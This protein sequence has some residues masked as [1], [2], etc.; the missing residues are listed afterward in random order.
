MRDHQA[1]AANELGGRAATV[2]ARGRLSRAVSYSPARVG[3]L[4]GKYEVAGRLGGGGMAEVFVASVT[5]AE[6]FARRVAVKRV[7][8][9]FSTNP[10]FAKM[11]VAEAKISSRLQ[12]PNIV[13]VLD[14]DRDEEERLFLVMELIEGKD[15]DALAA[16]GPL[17]ISVIIFVITEALRGLGYAHDLP[18]VDDVAMRGSVTIRA[19]RGVVHRDVSPH[20]VLLS[21]EGVVKVSDFGIAKARN[22]T[23]ATA[24]DVIKGKPAYMSPEQ[25]NGEDL[26]GR[27]DLF[28]IGVMLW[29]LLCG[30]RLF[31]GDDTRSMLAAVLFRAIPRP[32][33]VRAA[34]PKDLERVVMKLLERD[35]GARYE[36]AEAVIVDLVACVAAPKDGRAEL[37]RVMAERF[38]AE[39]PVRHSVLRVRQRDGSDAVPQHIPSHD[40]PTIAMT[41][42]PDPQDRGLP[43]A[44]GLPVVSPIRSRRG[45]WVVGSVALTAIT[46]IIT[47]AVAA[48]ARKSEGPPPPV[49]AAPIAAVDAQTT[50]FVPPTQ[51]ADLR[52]VSSDARVTD[53]GSANAASDANDANDAAAPP[54][55]DPKPDAKASTQLARP[56]TEKRGRLQVRAF[57]S[58]TVYIDRRKLHDT[59]LD[60]QLAVGNHSVRLVNYDIGH[61]ETVNVIIRENQTTIIER[62]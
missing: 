54:V 53:A 59:P 29:E 10:A 2:P 51:D 18:V 15:L 62:D 44:H 16:S 46:A 4:S 21:W 25:A 56:S 12:H 33:T 27:S 20:N 42:E 5:G 9:G 38:S 43:G 45:R 7:L 11:F 8:P 6:G 49:G 14:F 22:T 26:D 58:L 57:P 23:S 36:T 37:K 3:V 1:H 24:S 50:A 31:T 35:L 61:D 40:R 17:P 28:A 47:L 34:I 39:A 32:R 13:S 48:G 41:A 30:R 52:T 55:A 60:R 19:M